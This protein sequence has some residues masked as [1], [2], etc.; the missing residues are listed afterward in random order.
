MD[1]PLV[2]VDSNSLSFKTTKEISFSAALI[3]NNIDNRFVVV[4]N[5][6]R[7]NFAI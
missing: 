4:T 3:F 7:L 2:I 6:D 1:D 5:I